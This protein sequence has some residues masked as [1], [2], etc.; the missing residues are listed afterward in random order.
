MAAV[1][2]GVLLIIVGLSGVFCIPP[3]FDNR[4]APTDVTSTRDHELLRH[5]PATRASLGSNFKYKYVGEG[6]VISST[7][8]S[9]GY[10]FEI[11]ATRAVSE[12]AHEKAAEI[13]SKMTRYMPRDIFDRLATHATAGVFTKEEHLTVYPEYRSLADTPQCHHSCSGSCQK[14][15]GFD[16]RKYETLAGVG[17]KRAV[18]LDDNILCDR[19]DPYH[20]TNN[21][22]I[23]EFTHTVHN[24]A[25]SSFWKDQI[26]AAY[27][28]A[29]AHHIWTSSSYAMSNYL[30]Y[31]AEASTTFF[32]GEHM[33]SGAGGMNMCSGRFCTSEHAMRENLRQKDPQLFT[34][35]SHVFTSDRP[36]TPGGLGPCA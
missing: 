11:A 35:L 16:G 29:K 9:S 32:N 33:H 12:T 28:H 1:T 14:T 10:W 34:V 27:N 18:I 17:G 6:G 21:I 31:F 36:S 22:L 15:C 19:S 20:R 25:L 30:E 24:Y 8:H 5:L 23:H 3:A 26:T 2:G 7:R 13:I 4:T